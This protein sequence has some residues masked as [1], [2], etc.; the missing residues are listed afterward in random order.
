MSGFFPSAEI[1]KTGLA[2]ASV[3]LQMISRGVEGRDTRPVY[4]SCRLHSSD[5]TVK[6]PPDPTAMIPDSAVLAIA[7]CNR[8]ISA[9]IAAEKLLL[10]SASSPS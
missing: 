10:S 1:M 3:G 6:D 4:D 2:A 5:A 9:D 8:S 7:R